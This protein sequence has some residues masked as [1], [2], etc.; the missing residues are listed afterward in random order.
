MRNPYD[1]AIEFVRE[2]VITVD[3]S[4]SDDAI[5][6]AERW[7]ERHARD[8]EEIRIVATSVNMEY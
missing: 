3:A 4:N 6:K 2:E 8:G 7:A 5:A 1:V